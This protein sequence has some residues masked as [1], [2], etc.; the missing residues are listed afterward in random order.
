VVDEGHEINMAS[1]KA[2]AGF[3][4]HAGRSEEGNERPA[5]KLAGNASLCPEGPD[6][7]VAIRYSPMILT[8][9][10]LRRRPS[11]SP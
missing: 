11:N 8:R 3:S 6:V 9:T 5:M 1:F 4:S 10:R 2:K 7:F